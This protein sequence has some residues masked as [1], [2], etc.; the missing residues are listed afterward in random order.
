MNIDQSSQKAGLT[1]NTSLEVFMLGVSLISFINLFLLLILR[2][3]DARQVVV[4]IDWLVA[5]LFLIDFIR[6]IVVAKDRRDYFFH[7]FGW[8]DLL[9]AIPLASFNVFRIFRIARFLSFAHKVGIN[10][11]RHILRVTIADT[12]LY[13]VMFLILLLLEFGS[14][15]VLLAENGAD[16]ANIESAS[17]ALWWVFVSI[18]TVGYGDTF[19]VTNIGR[20][21]GVVTIAVGVGL[22]GVVTGY[23]ANA[24]IRDKSE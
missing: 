9:A 22:F 10:K 11:V 23:V 1:K 6:R 15:A 20:L 3:S 2:D 19:P 14:I 24:F 17:D 18:T 13:A 4:V 21:V 12:A 8:S 5:C 7:Q 16:G